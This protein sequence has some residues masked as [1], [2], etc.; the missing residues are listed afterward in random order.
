MQSGAF[1]RSLFLSQNA[2]FFSDQEPHI[3]SNGVPTFQVNRSPRKERAVAFSVT[4]VWFYDFFFFFSTNAD[5]QSISLIGSVIRKSKKMAMAYTHNLTIFLALPPSGS[6]LSEEHLLSLLWLVCKYLFQIKILK[7]SVTIREIWHCLDMWK[8]M[9]AHDIQVVSKCI[10]LINCF[11]LC[12]LGWFHVLYESL[13]L[14]TF[15]DF[16][17]GK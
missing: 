4:P 9:L 16:Q 6:V 8:Y 10:I 11:L 3:L 1:G 14:G 13:S 2:L 15:C 7:T 12:G 5:H 17:S